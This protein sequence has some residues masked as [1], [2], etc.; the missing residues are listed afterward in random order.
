VRHG[1]SLW[2]GVHLSAVALIDCSILGVLSRVADRN[3]AHSMVVCA[4]PGTPARRLIDVAASSSRLGIAVYDTRGEA[5][6][7]AAVPAG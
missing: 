3:G 4:P 2:N 1:H 7:A 5:L 6:C